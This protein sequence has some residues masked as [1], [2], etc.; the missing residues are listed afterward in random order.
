VQDTTTTTQPSWAVEQ[1]RRIAAIWRAH[2]TLRLVALVA[3]AIAIN[4]MTWPSLWVSPQDGLDGSWQIALHL[5]ADQGMAF[6]S[7]IGFTYGPLGFLVFPLLVTGPTYALAFVATFAMRSLLILGLVVGARRAFGNGLIAV[8][9]AYAGAALFFTFPSELGGLLALVVALLFLQQPCRTTRWMFISSCLMGVATGLLL[10]V[11]LDG[12]MIA[13]AVLGVTAWV[14]GRGRAVAAWAGSAIVVTGALWLA[15]G[16]SPVDV[17]RWISWSAEIVTG[18]SGATMLEQPGRA[19]EYAIFLVLA[20]GLLALSAYAWR[21]RPM[22]QRL[23][24]SAVLALGVWATFKHGFVRHD[25]HAPFAIATIGV[26]PAIGAWREPAL[27]IAG[28]ILVLVGLFFAFQSTSDTTAHLLDPRG[29]PQ[30]AW[31]Q[32]E[33]IVD[34]S[35]RADEYAVDRQRLRDRLKVP[36]AILH[37][38]GHDAVHITPFEVAVAWTYGLNWQPLPQFQSFSTWTT[39]LDHVNGEALR[40]TAAP[41]YVLRANVKRTDSQSPIWQ[42]PDENLAL[43]CRYVPVVSTKRWQLLERSVN[44]CGAPMLIGMAEAHAGRPVTVPRAGRGHIVFARLH[45]TPDLGE[46]ALAVLF[47]PSR[48]PEI[49]LAGAWGRGRYR[50]PAALLDA[51]LVLR[52]PVPRGMPA[53]PAN[54]LRT[55]RITLI[56]PPHARVDFYEVPIRPR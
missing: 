41:R 14:Q 17:P 44:R 50:I 46:R 34:A 38:I 51:P 10:L 1:G 37:R 6:G 16:N 20:V 53:R 7:D 42:S 27:R 18:Y 52:A 55:D 21:T 3:V 43:L 33:M 19:W 22:V 35:A 23:A 45:W 24:L 26:L 32:A 56:Y 40:G 36:P 54:L 48:I 15:A 31:T 12:G 47:K 11:K 8:P 30:S 29:R 28:G 49:R 13:I 9:I 5:A 25:S 4:L 2:R 39:A